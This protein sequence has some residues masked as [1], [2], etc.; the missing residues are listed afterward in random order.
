MGLPKLLEDMLKA[1]MDN[2]TLQNWNIYQDRNGIVNVRLRFNGSHDEPFQQVSYKRKSPKQISHD[3]ERSKQWRTVKPTIEQELSDPQP[4]Q[5]A[6]AQSLQSASTPLSNEGVKTRAM[7]RSE[8]EVPRSPDTAPDYTMNVYADSFIMPQDDITLTAQTD[9]DDPS[10]SLSPD[11]SS[12]ARE[13]GL[14]K[15]IET[16]PLQSDSTLTDVPIQNEQAVKQT[17]LKGYVS[18]SRRPGKRFATCA[19]CGWNKTRTHCCRCDVVICVRCI[20]RDKHSR[21]ISNYGYYVH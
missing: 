13:S 19:Y 8:T 14:N 7:A 12:F 21:H 18:P 20:E 15:D 11:L 2:N 5:S 6:I 1:I 17:V 10:L 9:T 16:E 4:E 3:L